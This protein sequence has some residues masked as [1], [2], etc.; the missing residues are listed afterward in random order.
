M[1]IDQ[2][3]KRMETLFFE[4]KYE[5]CKKV[6][7]ELL[8]VVD[9]DFDKV[10][11]LQAI[12]DCVQRLGDVKGAIP[13]YHEALDLARK[14]NYL[15]EL[16]QIL[17]RLA[18]IEYFIED[19]TENAIEFLIEC[20]DKS[21]EYDDSYYIKS[22]LYMLT[23][24]YYN[25]FNYS[26]ALTLAEETL[27]YLDPQNEDY[28]KKFF[29]INCLIGICNLALGNYDD[30]KKYYNIAF[31]S[32]IDAKDLQKEDIK[33]LSD[34]YN[35]SYVLYSVCQDE[36]NHP[37]LS[38]I[39]ENLFPEKYEEIL[40]LLACEEDS[41][42]DDVVPTLMDILDDKYPHDV[43]ISAIKA[44][45]YTLGPHD[46]LFIHLLNKKHLKYRLT[47]KINKKAADIRDQL[48]KTIDYIKSKKPCNK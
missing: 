43:K 30:F 2:G 26:Q 16:I 34:V 14:I 21:K 13:Y 27:Q 20:I 28:L 45:S 31:D 42:K 8:E 32:I 38:D 25:S 19:N 22:S 10:E 6:C 35:H 15:F 23:R 29:D 39:I 46:A 3:F 1:D 37:I 47:G 33:K 12:G 44:I 9:N 17:T 4:E 40:Y 18:S 7:E 36:K 24:V 41:Y 48:K 5:E 11:L